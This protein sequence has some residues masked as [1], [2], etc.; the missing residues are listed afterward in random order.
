MATFFDAFVHLTNWGT[1]WLIL[2]LPHA[3]ITAEKLRAYRT[4]GE[5]LTYREEGDH[6][7]LSFYANSENHDWVE[8]EGWLT[9]LTPLCSAL[10]GGDERCLYLGWLLGVQV[11]EVEDS[12][13]P[14]PPGLG[15]LDEP[16]HALVDLFGLDADPIAAAAAAEHRG[17]LE[18]RPLSTERLARWVGEMA[19]ADRDALLV[20][21]L[22]E[23]NAYQPQHELRL[24]RQRARREIEAASGAR[25]RTQAS[26]RFHAA[27]RGSPRGSF[28][29]SA[30]R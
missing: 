29:W 23:G 21:L 16:L 3:L 22:S 4:L 15:A 1:R 11:G 28:P 20:S 9:T 2:R 27:P 30:A 5:A 19:A 26:Q 18:A 8:G 13:P 12:E 25:L 24:L 7:V 14:V 6:T 17:P 10:L